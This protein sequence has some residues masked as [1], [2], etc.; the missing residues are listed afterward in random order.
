[1]SLNKIESAQGLRVRS[2]QDLA[3][4]IFMILL[5]ALALYLSRDLAA[6]TLRQLGPGML[7]K[8]FAWICMGLGVMLALGSLRFKGER[9]SPISFRNILFVMGGVCVFALTI[10][11]FASRDRW[12]CSSRGSRRKT[13]GCR[14]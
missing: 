14:S 8:S 4:G 5:A 6:G 11:G 13:A 10:R 2:T 7:P 12:S 9:L 3:A 1:M